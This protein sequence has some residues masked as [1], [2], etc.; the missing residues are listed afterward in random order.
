MR[1]GLFGVSLLAALAL[2]LALGGTWGCAQL[3]P[4]RSDEDDDDNDDDDGSSDADTDSDADSDA[5][6]DADGDTDVDTDS[7]TDS[8]TGADT[9][10]DADSDTDADTDADADSDADADTDADADSDADADTDADTDGDTDVSQSTYSQYF[11]GGSCTDQCAAWI[12][13]KAGL[14]TSGYTMVT[15][16]GSADPAG[17]S[18][19]DPV[20]VQQIADM[21]RTT[22][23]GSVWCNGHTWSQCNRYEGEFWI[24]PPS[25]CD[26]SNCPSPGRIVRPCFSLG[27]C[28]YSA[29]NGP[30]CSAPPQT[31]TLS[32]Y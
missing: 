31:I 27:G 9:D 1:Q 13:F 32:F 23:D 18:C 8:D 10:S 22:A 17:I 28:I 15:L 14:A 25:V 16:S 12:S 30:T 26:L 7:E 29:L 20:A 11:D 5:D 2:A 21:I 3:S 19:S 6:A 4:I 24:D